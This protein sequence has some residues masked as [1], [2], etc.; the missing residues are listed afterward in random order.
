[1]SA[2][3]GSALVGGIVW[4]RELWNYWKPRRVG[5][6]GP[7]LAGKTTLDRYLT[8]PGEM[9]DISLEDRTKHM[10]ILGRYILP[11]PT[12]KRVSWKGEKRVVYSADIGGDERFWSLWIDDMVDR[13]V[14]AVVFLFDHRAM[15]GGDAAIQAVGGF[16]Y[17]V[18]ALIHKQYRYRGF[19]TWWRGK[20]YS[21]KIVLLVAN[22]AD[23]WWDDQA[24][25]L[26]QQQRLGEHKMFDPFREDLIR[27]QKAGIPTNRSMMATKIGWN[28]EP[29]MVDLLSG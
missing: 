24:N 16:K 26:W 14:E 18:D 7:A 4:A 22:K 29:T 17:L 6:Y 3:A 20:K 19:K 1:M 8:T 2:I 11:R 12:R 27:L 15:Q 9:E 21:P 10:R 25:T 5:I 13:Q 28:V 23:Q